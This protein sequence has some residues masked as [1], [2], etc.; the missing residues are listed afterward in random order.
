MRVLTP[1]RASLYQLWHA[2]DEDG[3]AAFDKVVTPRAADRNTRS[4]SLDYG[5]RNLVIWF[6]QQVNAEAT[7][8]GLPLGSAAANVVRR[9]IPASERDRLLGFAPKSVIPQPLSFMPVPSVVPGPQDEQEA[10]DDAVADAMDAATDVEQEQEMPDQDDFA[11]QEAG[12]FPFTLPWWGWA[13]IV[14]GAVGLSV[15][16]YWYTKKRRPEALEE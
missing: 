14:T 4:R 10:I 16:G 13:G 3:L 5:P 1:L 11:V 8:L 9:G 15:F 6:N 2:A 12:M 7:Q